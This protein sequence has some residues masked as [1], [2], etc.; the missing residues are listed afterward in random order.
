MV[1]GIRETKG[2]AS[3]VRFRRG[4]GGGKYNRVNVLSLL[5]TVIRKEHCN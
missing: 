5:I 1:Y 2:K 4:K 3:E